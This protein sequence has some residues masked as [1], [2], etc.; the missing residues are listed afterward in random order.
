[1][2][3]ISGAIRLCLA[4]AS[5]ALMLGKSAS[6]AYARAVTSH[7]QE[8]PVGARVFHE[9]HGLGRLM[10]LDFDNP[11]GK[12][13]FVTFDGGDSHHYSASSMR[14]LEVV[15]AGA[16]LPKQESK[17]GIIP[18]Q[19][20]GVGYAA[21]HTVASLCEPLLQDCMLRHE[22]NKSKICVC[23]RRATP[24]EQIPA[25]RQSVHFVTMH[26]MPKSTLA[27]GF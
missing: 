4:V 27:A 14:K 7:K 18:R 5:L 17:R 13:Y 21:C 12:P 10:E 23:K 9:K 25:A 11:S 3:G 8:L 22:A 19:P 16:K 6:T 26:R 1:M 20:L 15:E 24:H 2:R